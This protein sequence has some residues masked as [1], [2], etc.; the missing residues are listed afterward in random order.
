MCCVKETCYQ[1]WPPS[2]SQTFGEFKVELLG[3]EMMDNA[4]L[5][6]L[7][8]THSEVQ[9]FF[10]IL[11]AVLEIIVLCVSTKT[12]L[13]FPPFPPPTPLQ[14]TGKPPHQVS[15]FQI[16]NWAPDGSCGKLNSVSRVVEE[17]NKIQRRTGNHTITVHCR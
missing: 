17:M 2:G 6:T 9:N 1:Y 11:L 8:V 4:V 14:Q 15:Q 5:K 7:S 13:L 3:E 16:T 10:Y 12:F